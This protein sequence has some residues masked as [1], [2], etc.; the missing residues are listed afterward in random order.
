MVQMDHP[1]GPMRQCHHITASPARPSL[2]LI[3]V[4]HRQLSCCPELVNMSLGTELLQLFP[5]YAS[6]SCRNARTST[7]DGDPDDDSSDFVASSSYLDMLADTYRNVAYRIALEKAAS[8]GMN[9]R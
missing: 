2:K 4:A 3:M 6:W 1:M 9:A 7:G 8:A 5:A